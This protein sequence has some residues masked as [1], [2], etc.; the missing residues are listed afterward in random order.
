[1]VDVYLSAVAVC[2]RPIEMTDITLFT[3]YLHI[4]NA[5]TPTNTPAIFDCLKRLAWS[6]RKLLY[7]SR[8]TCLIETNVVQRE[9]TFVSQIWACFSVKCLVRI[10]FLYN[11]KLTAAVCKVHA[12]AATLY[13]VLLHSR[14]TFCFHWC[15]Q[16]VFFVSN[17][18]P[19][20][21][22]L[23]TFISTFVLQI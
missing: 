11:W 14:G 2:V 3:N 12:C 5:T 23:K 4:Y 13:L 22:P 15:A 1:M 20:V 21:L 9:P 6:S 10:H 17:K 18:Q 19:A 7:S 8:V 16:N